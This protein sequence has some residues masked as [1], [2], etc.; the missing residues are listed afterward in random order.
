LRWRIGTSTF[1]N[2]EG[3][4]IDD[5]SISTSALPPS[6]TDVVSPAHGAVNVSATT[7]LRWTTGGGSPSGYKLFFGT[8]NPPTNLINGTNLGNVLT[9]DPPGNLNFLT[10]YYWKVV[11]TNMNGDALGCTIWS[12]T[13]GADTRSNI[14]SPDGGGYL[15]SASHST[16]SPRP[17]YEWHPSGPT[18]SSVADSLLTG[19][20]QD[21][22]L[23]AIVRLPSPFQF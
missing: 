19:T 6:C 10:T 8:D 15:Y 21:D 16:I 5:V 11:P 1:V 22:A 12:F 9:Y 14:S 17:N 2:D 7:A 3:W 4:A 13:T 23:S 18:G 20:S